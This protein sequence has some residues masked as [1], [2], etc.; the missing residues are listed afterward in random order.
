MDIKIGTSGFY[1]KD[2]IGKVYPDEIKKEDIFDYYINNFE[3][4][5][6]ELNVSYYKIISGRVYD[7]FIRRCKDDFNFIIKAYKGITHDAIERGTWELKPDF[8]IAKNFRASITTMERSG[9]LGGILYQFPPFYFPKRETLDY[10][11]KIKDINGDLPMFV[12]F[13]NRY[14]ERD[15]YIFELRN[16]QINIC[17]V[18]LPKFDKLPNYKIVKA[19]DIAYF[20]FHGRNK[21]WYKKNIDRYDYLYNNNEL[22]DFTKDI[23]NILGNVSKIYAFFNNCH[24]GQAVINAKMLVNLMKNTT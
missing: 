10:I 14:W 24:A 4:N 23:K 3:F 19:N 12:E 21:N 9:K 13:R 5:T 22:K 1:F 17:T 11:K 20:R 7:S 8:D 2:W 15:E 16:N 18:D 6:I